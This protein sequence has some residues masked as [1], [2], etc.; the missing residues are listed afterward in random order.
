MAYNEYLLK[1]DK[2][3]FIFPEKYIEWGSYKSKPGQRQSLDAY[4]DLDG[5]THDN[6]LP[7][8]KTEISFTTLP[9]SGEEWELL[10]SNVVG[11]YLNFEAR[12]LNITYFDFEQCKYRSGHFYFD[13]SFQVNANKNKNGA[14]LRYERA[15]WLFI[16]Y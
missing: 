2:A 1:F 13:K 15:E 8:A 14:G 4:T 3:N 6:P 7:H 16:E 10:M 9:M 11:N 5:V 12:D